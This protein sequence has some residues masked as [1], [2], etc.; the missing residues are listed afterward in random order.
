MPTEYHKFRCPIC[1]GDFYCDMGYKIKARY[2]NGELKELVP[3]GIEKRDSASAN[4][5]ADDI[6]VSL[7]EHLYNGITIKKLCKMLHDIYGIVEDYCCDM[8][9][10]LKL[11]LCMYCPDRCHLY[12]VDERTR[13]RAESIN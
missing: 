11:K 7:Q 9:Q 6:I 5:L 1:N 2:K 12:F 10:R 13:S 4:Q 8:I 3:Q